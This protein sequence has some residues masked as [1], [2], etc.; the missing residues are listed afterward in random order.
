VLSFLLSVRNIAFGYLVGSQLIG[1][2]WS[3]SLEDQFYF[4]LPLFLFFV[5]A[6]KWRIRFLWLV[7]GSQFFVFRKEWGLLWHIRTDALAWGVLLYYFSNTPFYREVEPRFLSNRFKALALFLVLLF[8]LA[9]VPQ[10]LVQLPFSVGLTAML[11][12]IF[13]W[14]ASY[15]RDYTLPFGRTF[16]QYVGSR[17]YGIYLTHNPAFY[18]SKEICYRYAH[19]HSTEITDSYAPYLFAIGMVLTVIFAEFSYRWIE[20][21][22]RERGKRVASQIGS[23]HTPHSRSMPIV[24][25][26]Q[27]TEMPNAF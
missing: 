17:S 13:V 24:E 16:F 23:G 21:P 25:R 1:S 12:A 5:R 2:Y 6:D 22:L 8:A 11:S 4:F 14:I 10:T 26:S 20:T 18:F 15:N 27:F 3:L 19:A 9:F 7:I